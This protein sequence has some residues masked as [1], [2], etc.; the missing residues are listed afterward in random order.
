MYLPVTD[1]YE[2]ICQSMRLERAVSFRQMKPLHSI[3][4]LINRLILWGVVLIAVLQMAASAQSLKPENGDD[5]PAVAAP[6]NGPRG[7]S[8]DAKGNVYIAEMVG[9]RVRKVNA[10]T[11]LISTVASN[12]AEC[13]FQ[14]GMSATAKNRITL[15][16]ST[17][18]T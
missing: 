11:G 14:E 9:R 4:R 16:H 2:S 6:I 8:I 15:L 10:K 3:V 1:S 18:L 5:G 7:I 17:Q 12:G 13:C